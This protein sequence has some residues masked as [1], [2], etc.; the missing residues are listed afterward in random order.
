PPPPPPFTK[1]NPP[2]P[3]PFTKGNPPP[4]PPSQSPPV[5]KDGSPLPKL[6]P[7][8]WDKVRAAPD[9]S[10]VWDKLRTSSFEFDE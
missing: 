1:G 3:P 10:M 6:K 7:L 5:G 9:R 2:P 8:H 4:P